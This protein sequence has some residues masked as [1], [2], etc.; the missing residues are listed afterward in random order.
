MITKK[1][2]D[3]TLFL[4][5]LE[6]FKQGRIPTMYEEYQPSIHKNTTRLRSAYDEMELIIVELRELLEHQTN[7]IARRD[8][9]IAKLEVDLYLE[10]RGKEK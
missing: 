3:N 9:R 4:I 1:D 6:S 2:F 10:R 7:A 8:E 5:E